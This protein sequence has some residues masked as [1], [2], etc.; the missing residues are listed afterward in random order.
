MTTATPGSSGSAC[1]DHSFVFA[2]S[3][4][5][6]GYAYETIPNRRILAG[7]E[8]G[9]YAEPGSDDVGP[10][11]QAGRSALGALALGAAGVPIWRK[12][13]EASLKMAGA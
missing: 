3:A 11:A 1:D 7:Q 10:I 4:T 2:M 12:E 8:E 6:T 5:L 9:S 13:E